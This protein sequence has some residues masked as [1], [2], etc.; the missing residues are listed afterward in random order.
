M[1]K[2]LRIR[3]VEPTVFFVRDGGALRQLTRLTLDNPGHEAQASLRVRAEGVDESVSLNPV[4]SG[5]TVCEAYLPDIRAAVPV[6]LSLLCD[7]IL[8]DETTIDWKP[9][10]HWEVYLVHYAHHDMGYTDLPSNVRAEYNDFMDQ[11]LG[12]CE[13]TENW[14]E[15]EARFRYQCEQAW[16]AV[17]YIENRPPEVIERLTHFI[18]NGQIEVTALFGNQTLE[19]CGHEELVR[20]LYPAFRLK[21]DHGIAISSAE[22]NDIPG[23]T[24][25][26]ASVLAGAGVRY[27]S[28][29]VPRWYFHG[30][31]PLW[32]TEQCVPLEMPGACWWEGPDGARVLLWS[33]LHGIEWQPYDF[34]QAM[35]ELPG[36]LRGL[37]DGAYPWDMVSYTLRGGHRDNAPPTI[38]YAHLVR[39]WNSRWAYPRLVNSTNT[40]FLEVFEKRWGH[41]LKT[42]RGDVPG[43]DY[44]VGATGT[45]KETAVDRNTHEWLM[46]A[47]KL[48]TLASAIGDYDYPRAYLDKAYRQTFYYDLHAWGHHQPGGPT[49]DAHWNEKAGFAYN[50]AALAYDVMIKASNAITD[51]IAYPDD[52]PYVTVFNTLSHDRSDVVRI[53]LRSWSPCGFPMYWRE[54]DEEG[55]WP[56]YVAGTVVGRAMVDQEEALLDQP[57]EIVDASTGAAVPYQICTLTHPQSASPWAPERVALGERNTS[58]IVLSA[59][60]LPSV[61]Y[62]TYRI[63]RC[64]RWP[65]FEPRSLNA[66]PTGS[67]GRHV[68]ENRFY[69]LELDA[70][71]GTVVSLFD[72]TLERELVD[73]DAPHGF[74]QFFMRHS[75]TAEEE[76]LRITDVSVCETGPVYTTLRLRGE[77][78]CCPRVTIEITLYETL[79]RIDVRARVLRDSTARNEVYMAFPFDVE[80]PEFRFEAPGSVI[81]PTRDQWPGSSTD[82]YAV[83]HWAD[84]FNDDWGVVWSALDTPM[85]EF[86]GLWPGYVSRAHHLAT[87]PDYGHPFV[88]PGGLT[89]GHIY[90]LISYNNFGTNF[91]NVLPGEYLVRFSFGAHEG[92]WREGRAPEFGWNV[93]NPPLPVWMNGPQAGGSLPLSASFCQVEARN[94]MALTFKKAE[95]G[96]GYILR[97]IET[98]GKE[99]TTAVHVPHLALRHV[100]ETNLVEE[101]QRVLPCGPHSMEVTVGPFAM[102]TFRLGGEM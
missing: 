79:K 69:R 95:D 43:T 15:E 57:F 58:E 36:M 20:L 7:G 62:R 17:H 34:E 67:D 18:K 99:T 22:H 12:Y 50:A 94:V 90:A 27:F 46:S 4:P 10:K 51:Q 63:V 25:G 97:L 31:H 29:G 55:G 86:G 24:W 101:N 89:Q 102:V 96:N 30:V 60:G 6:T 61:G 70:Q 45:P 21:R 23:F 11:V 33:D 87:G 37:E 3:T 77:M 1:A 39:T 40:P 35:D 64:D 80:N 53:P 76:P 47:E 13:E 73:G 56:S 5:E 74:G 75:E 48:A 78:S 41:T 92:D 82:S 49:L 84:V 26:L 32:D 100:F 16:S 83:Q 59:D 88:P 54:P 28:P 38:R 68:V 66:G 2:N 8:Q 71:S 44:P 98:E 81:E 52:A 19:L 85:A 65:E 91:I 42:L 14:P 93:T 72:R 9:E